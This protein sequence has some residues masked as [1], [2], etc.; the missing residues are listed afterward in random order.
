MLR[1]PQNGFYNGSRCFVPTISRLKHEKSVLTRAL[2]SENR[3]IRANSERIF[4]NRKFQKSVI[5]SFLDQ[6]ES[7]AGHSVTTRSFT[8]PSGWFGVCRNRN[9]NCC[10]G[11]IRPTPPTRLHGTMTHP[12][13]EGWGRRALP[14]SASRTTQRLGPTGPGLQ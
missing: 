6:L 5:S 13:C 7:N 2:R 4:I 10:R 3:E 14:P 8:T 11:I 12:L 9:S 1:N